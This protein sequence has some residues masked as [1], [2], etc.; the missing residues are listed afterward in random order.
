MA[1]LLEPPDPDAVHDRASFLA[2]VAALAAHRRASVAAEAASASSPWGPDA[3]GWE[4][5][6]IER[7]LDAAYRWAVDMG[8]RPHG[9]PAEPSWRSFAEFLYCGR[10]YE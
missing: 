4:N 2:F 6:T 3:G 7:Y 9:L 1:E 10:S 5:T 8:A